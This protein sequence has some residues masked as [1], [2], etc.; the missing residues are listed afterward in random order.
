MPWLYSTAAYLETCGPNVRDF[1]K[2]V[3]FWNPLNRWRKK[4]TLCHASSSSIGI[5][6][7]EAYFQRPYSAAYLSY[8]KWGH[9]S[10][11]PWCFH[12]N[13]ISFGH[14]GVQKKTAFISSHQVA[15]ST[16][17]A[18]YFILCKSTIQ[19]MYIYIC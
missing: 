3:T 1:Q 19:Y 15:S 5:Y 14:L 8:W 11:T 9:I 2:W 4:Q 6:G 10:V 18:T 17:T 12:P 16:T 13:L 7:S